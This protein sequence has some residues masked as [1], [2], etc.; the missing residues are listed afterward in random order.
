MQLAISNCQFIFWP[1]KFYCVLSVAQLP[2]ASPSTTC[3]T[4]A[5][6]TATKTSEASATS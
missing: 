4:A 1:L 3:A 2:I 6:A 5:T